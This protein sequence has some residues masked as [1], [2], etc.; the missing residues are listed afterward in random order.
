MEFEDKGLTKPFVR[1]TLKG[2][3]FKL[4]NVSALIAVVVKRKRKKYRNFNKL[5]MAKAIRHL[6]S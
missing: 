4:Q 1:Q 5:A 2:K 3:V 6:N